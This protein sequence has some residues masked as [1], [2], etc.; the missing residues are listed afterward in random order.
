MAKVS[1]YGDDGVTDCL[2]KG[3]EN[4]LWFLQETWSSC[5]DEDKIKF[6]DAIMSIEELR[7]WFE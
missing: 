6:Y 1:D 5:N 7:K 3:G 2:K 4:K